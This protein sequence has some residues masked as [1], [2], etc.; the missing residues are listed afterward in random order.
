[1]GGLPSVAER[2]GPGDQRLRVSAA[3]LQDRPSSLLPLIAGAAARYYEQEQWLNSRADAASISSG[4]T[5]RVTDSSRTQS[6]SSTHG[7][8]PTRP[9]TPPGHPA[10]IFAHTQTAVL[11]DQAAVPA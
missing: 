6:E 10:E 7:C 2:A 11:T 5:Y 3:G 4:V 1:M 9:I 8:T